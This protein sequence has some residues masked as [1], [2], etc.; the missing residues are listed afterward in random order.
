ME[1]EQ[2]DRQSR[3][4]VA[5]DFDGTLTIRD[6]YTEFLRW[7][8]G[9]GAYLAGLVTLA[10][11]LMAYPV[12][13][14]RGRLKAAATRLFL[15]ETPVEVL[16]AAAAQFCDRVWDDFMRP[17]AL[18]CWQAWGNKGVQ[19]VIVTASPRLTVQPFAR[20]L[21]ADG[22]IGT[23]LEVRQGVL[24]GD[25]ASPNCRGAEKVRRLQAVFGPELKLVAAYGDTSGD[26]EM[27]AMA[28]HSGWR[29]FV[30][31]P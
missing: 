20:R 12:R 1:I 11:E 28:E 3:P 22:L 2:A 15:A 14:D 23:E 8:A 13:R 5:F 4:V 27:L 7:N 30:K 29:E 9:S 10:P 6:S 21:G 31:K 19:R 17:D 24:T 16:E 18:A 25:F 26:T